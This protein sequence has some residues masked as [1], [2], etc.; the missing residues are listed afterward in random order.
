[1]QSDSWR[2]AAALRDVG[3]D[4]TLDVWDGLWHVWQMWP[5]LPESAE[6]FDQLTDHLM[7][8]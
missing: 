5:D 6:A 7:N 1:M 4:T 8:G 2:L 3:V